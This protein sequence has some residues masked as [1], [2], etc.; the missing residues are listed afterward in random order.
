MFSKTCWVRR[1]SCIT[2]VAFVVPL[3]FR[4]FVA[5]LKRQAGDIHGGTCNAT[6]KH[7]HFTGTWEVAM[8]H[9]DIE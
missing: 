8:S 2:F 9:P 1:Q 4:S 5:D 7:P 6:V 3:G